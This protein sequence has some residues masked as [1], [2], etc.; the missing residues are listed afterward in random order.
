[1]GPGPSVA[2]PRALRA[3]AAPLVGH[4]SNVMLQQMDEIKQG[5]QY[6]FQTASPYVCLLSGTGHGGMEACLVNLLERGER[7]VI[8]QNG[9]WGERAADMAERL[10]LEPVVLRTGKDDE[11]G[12]AF[13][14]DT[15]IAAVRQHKPS[16]LFVV[17]GES[18]T[19]AH[20]SLGGGRLGQACRDAGALLI[21][22]TVAS[23]G[24][25]PFL[26]DAWGVDACYSGSQKVL[27]GPPGAAPLC[28][29]ERAWSKIQARTTKIASF[30][31]D[32]PMIGRYWQWQPGA[33]RV[34]HHTGAVST[35]FAL[36]ECLAV[37]GE[38]GLEAMWKRHSDAAAMLW[39]G[40]A[41]LGLE[42]YVAD[43]QYR[44]V[45]VNTIRVPDGADWAALVG[46]CL[47]EYDLE[48]AGG[49]GPSAGRVWRVGLMGYSCTRANVALVLEAFRTGL[50]AQGWT[51]KK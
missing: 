13:P 41:E 20:Q 4:L 8:A 50:E 44:L 47:K 22:D 35:Y 28:L 27:S 7:V 25:V 34:Y 46:H 23:L 6:L 40:L 48:I 5:L 3:Q 32:L 33:P 19:G 37:V 18:S 30:N 29:S 2:H 49:L 21:V 43:P 11:G 14:V 10:Q 45:T 12:S 31:W 38:E 1:M 42:P 51:K 39:R 16:A 24:G 36:R 9:I 17:V 26:A 15:L